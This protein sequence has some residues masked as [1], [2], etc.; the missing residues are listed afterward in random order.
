[1]KLIRRGI[2]ST[3]SPLKF[4]ANSIG[5]VLNAIKMT[6]ESPTTSFD[7]TAG[8]PPPYMEFVISRVSHASLNAAV[9][10]IENLVFAHIVGSQHSFSNGVDLTGVNPD[11]VTV[12]IDRKTATDS[13]YL[14]FGLIQFVFELDYTLTNLTET[15]RTLLTRVP[16]L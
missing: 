11:T 7:P 9:T 12:G 3:T 16:Y 2:G 10:D 14:H 8:D 1:M 13:L 15:E 6:P 4:E 5:V